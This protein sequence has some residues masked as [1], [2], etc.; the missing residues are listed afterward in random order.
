MDKASG[1]RAA[2]MISAL[3]IAVLPQLSVAQDPARVQPR[4]YRVVFEN[5]EVRVL[6]FAALPGMGVCGTGMHYHPRHLTILQTDARVRVRE[7]GKVFTVANKS[8]DVFWSEAG[9]HETENI[10]GSG[11]RSLL[12]EFK[13]AAP[14]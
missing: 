6:Q 2:K 1:V 14:R 12:V 4:S 11:V 5:S 8:G 7:N 3:A 13:T 9:R 10:S